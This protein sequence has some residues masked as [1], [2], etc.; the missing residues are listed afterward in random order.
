MEEHYFKIDSGKWRR[1]R[2]KFAGHLQTTTIEDES[3]ALASQQTLL[4]VP[5][6]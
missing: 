5:P 1:L 3:G 2:L 6:C 4:P